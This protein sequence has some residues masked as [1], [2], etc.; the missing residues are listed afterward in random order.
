MQHLGVKLHELGQCIR[1]AGVRTGMVMVVHV[2]DPMAVMIEAAR[3]DIAGYACPMPP[4]GW[5]VTLSTP[6]YRGN[7]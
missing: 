5:T 3:T 2:R 6:Y 7:G 1:R 4:G